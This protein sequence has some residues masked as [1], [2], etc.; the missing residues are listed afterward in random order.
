MNRR[1]RAKHG[2]GAAVR[3][4]FPK[5]QFD[6]HMFVELKDGRLWMLARTNY[7]IAES[8]SADQ[9][10]TWSEPQASKIGHTS[11][12]FHLRRLASGRL[13]LVRSTARSR[14]ERPSDRISP[15]MC[16]TMKGKPGAAA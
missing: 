2:H 6:E 1:I 3:A 14:S 10:R 15:L 8:F 16:P 12:R 7:G 9:G 5:S 13:L 4:L 11:A